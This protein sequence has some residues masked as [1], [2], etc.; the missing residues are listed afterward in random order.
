[1][2]QYR[3]K[4][5]FY[6]VVFCILAIG[7]IISPPRVHAAQPPNVGSQ[8][9]EITW[10]MKPHPSLRVVSGNL[11][12]EEQLFH[13][14][15]RTRF[16]SPHGQIKPDADL[17]P[18]AGEG[19]LPSLDEPI[20][21]SFGLSVDGQE[22]WDGWEWKSAQEIPCGRAGCRHVVVELASTIRP[23]RV[24]VHTEIDGHPFLKRWIEVFNDG[25]RA[26]AIG[27]VYPMSGYLF[28]AARLK[29]NFPAADK[30]VFA[31]LRP[32]S[33]EPQR[34]GDFRWMTL[35][36]GE[37]RYGNSKYGMPFTVIRNQVT[38]ESFLVHF[39]WS[40]SYAFEFH[41]EHSL[42]ADSAALYFRVGLDGPAPFRV[43]RPG[44][45]VTTPF[46]YVGHVSED[47]DGA[48]QSLH[49]YLRTSATA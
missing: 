47:L 12:Y 5:L 18:G 24:K 39:G 20:A 13:G 27:K 48:V 30:G 23:I 28:Q 7:A 35:P 42:R 37:Y 31:I 4:F 33:F 49:R 46:A 38:G 6:A 19:E 36:E 41:N 15:L 32:A 34:E 2:L 45:A 8:Q 43:L 21:C 11:V 44:E 1:M 26:A 22:L 3:S 29:E 17:E 40:G 14:G 16:W 9:A 25:I 10:T